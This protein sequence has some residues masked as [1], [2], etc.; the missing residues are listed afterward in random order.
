[1]PEVPSHLKAV[2][3]EKLADSLVGDLRISTPRQV[4]GVS[5]FR[6]RPPWW[7]GCVAWVRP[8]T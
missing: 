8:L 4:E 7:W 2:L 1:M 6:A 3:L 5:F